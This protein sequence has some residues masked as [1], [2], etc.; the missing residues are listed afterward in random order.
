MARGFLTL[1]S[2]KEQGMG[3]L[4]WGVL[5][6]LPALFPT[7]QAQA[8][9][10]TILFVGNSFTFGASSPV[11]KY[12]ASSVTD[13]NGDGVGG[14]PALFKLFTQ[15]AGLEYQ[16]SLETAAGQTLE[17][18]W[19]NKRA[20]I[21]RP[22]DHVVLQEYSTLDSARPGDPAKLVTYSGKIAA[23][24]RARNPK[25]SIGLTATWSRP[26]LTYPAGEHWSGQPITRMAEDIRHAD[27]LARR[28]N[29]SIG[30]IHPVGEAFSCAI[31]AGIADPNPYDGLTFGQVNLWAFDQ[32]HAST[33]GYYLEAL[34][35]FAGVT[36]RDPRKLGREE[37]AANELG[38]S[39]DVAQRLQSVAWQMTL[40]SGCDPAGLKSS[41]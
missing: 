38:L 8:R 25:A 15:E 9:A 18:H 14:V 29:P 16:V 31:A 28:H 37:I 30:R 41:P 10:D 39:P 13:L 12:R 22:W 24:I 32:Y 34:V 35:V 5:M 26:G 1:A 19:H 6:L 20:L 21:G 40:G 11:W 4:R 17:W 33:E 23:L 7:H 3:G 27:D 2:S 36:G